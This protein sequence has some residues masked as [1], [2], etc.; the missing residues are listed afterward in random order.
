MIK[1]GQ[2]ESDS[3]R[4]KKILRF[5]SLLTLAGDYVDRG[6]NDECP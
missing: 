4:E 5:H 1:A 2:A 6:E 3:G